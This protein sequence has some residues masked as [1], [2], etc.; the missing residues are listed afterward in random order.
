VLQAVFIQCSFQRRKYKIFVNYRRR[1]QLAAVDTSLHIKPHHIVCLTGGT[2]PP[3]SVLDPCGLSD[4]SFDE[5]KYRPTYTREE[6]SIR[7]LSRQPFARGRQMSDGC[8]ISL[9][10]TTSSSFEV[11]ACCQRHGSY[12]ASN[13]FYLVV[14]IGAAIARVRTNHRL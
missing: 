4:I 14:V 5:Q 13:V 7:L 10:W 3:F 6:R 12:H 11:A 1:A 9:M 8:T 2:L